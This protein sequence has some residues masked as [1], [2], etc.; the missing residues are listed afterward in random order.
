MVLGKRIRELRSKKGFSQESFAD[1]CGLHRT[2]MGGIERG[3]RNL[4]IQTVLTVSKGLDLTMS[5]L[6]SGI[7]KQIDTAGHPRKAAPTLRK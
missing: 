5:E 7:E 4:T 3:E 6:L 1:H 2:Y